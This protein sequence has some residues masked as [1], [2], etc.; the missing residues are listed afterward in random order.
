MAYADLADVQGHNQEFT[1]GVATQP[2]A[3]QVTEWLEEYSIEIDAVLTMLGIVNPIDESDSPKAY[4]IVRR[5]NALAAAAVAEEAASSANSPNQSTHAQALRAEYKRLLDSIRKGDLPLPDWVRTGDSIVSDPS[6]GPSS[7]LD[8]G[9]LALDETVDT[10]AD[11]PID[12]NQ[13]QF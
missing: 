12:R 1:Y 9:F 8:D 13:V 11:F 10:C 5:M 6:R 4:K 7:H 2:T 3:A